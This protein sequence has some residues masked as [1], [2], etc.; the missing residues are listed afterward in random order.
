[1]A[2]LTAAPTSGANAAPS[3]DTLRERISLNRDWRFMKGD[4][5]EAGEALSYANLKPWLVAGGAEFAG[6]EATPDRPPGNPGGDVPF[7]QPQFDEAGWRQLNLPH[8]WGIE[9]PFKQEYPGETGK[10]PWWGVGWY[11]KHID[12]PA[13]DRGTCSCAP[14]AR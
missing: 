5:P 7:V 1:M 11:R 14:R 8:D 12:V 9:G 3:P 6:G 13:S 4:P 2:L 10:L